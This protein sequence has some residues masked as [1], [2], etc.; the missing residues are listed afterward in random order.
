MNFVILRNFRPSFSDSL[1]AT[2]GLCQTPL[3]SNGIAK[4]GTFFELPNFSRT[5]FSPFF[6]PVTG[7]IILNNDG[8]EGYTDEKIFAQNHCPEPAGAAIDAEA[9]FGEP[10]GRLVV[11]TGGGLCP[12]AQVLRNSLAGQ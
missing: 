9:N 12:L 1:S 4:V 11:D 10:G 6:S 2:C 5:F 7:F 8:C 3:V